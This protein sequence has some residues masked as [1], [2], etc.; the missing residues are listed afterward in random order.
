MFS[1]LLV[2]HRLWQRVEGEENYEVG[3]V[4]REEMQLLVMRIDY[5]LV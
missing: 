5:C 2:V 3:C 1:V 4:G